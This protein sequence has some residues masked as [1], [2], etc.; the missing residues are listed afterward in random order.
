MK[1][2]LAVMLLSGILTLYSSGI[3]NSIL[4]DLNNG[5]ISDESN[6]QFWF[7]DLSYFTNKTYDEQM[8]MIA[9][10]NL[11][12]SGYE[13]VKWSDWRLADESDISNLWEYTSQEIGEM[14]TPSYTVVN[15]YNGDISTG[16]RGRAN[17]QFTNSPEFYATLNIWKLNDT[18]NDKIIFG[19]RID[20][21][22]EFLGALVVADFSV[23]AP[24]PE[25][26]TILLL[27]SGLLG[28]G[29]FRKKFKR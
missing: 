3:A 12:Y 29:V 23:P 21:P 8:S 11:P 24:V 1:Q 5:V 4:I 7:Q 15:Q 10:L 13:N 16:W 2:K 19:T 25:P 28:L 22:S 20:V 18:W 17:Y 9:S 27:C 6:Y 26:A 14:F